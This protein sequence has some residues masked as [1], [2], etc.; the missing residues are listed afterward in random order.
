MLVPDDANPHDRN[1]VRVEIKGKL[2]GFL[3]RE[4][5]KRYRARLKTQKVACGPATCGAIVMG[6]FIRKDGTRASY[7]ARL[8]IEPF[9]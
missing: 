5:A 8:D 7:G 6:G 1:A 3:P 2:V 9:D 4:D